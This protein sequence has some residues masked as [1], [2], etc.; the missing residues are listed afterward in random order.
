MKAWLSIDFEDI[1]HDFK[2]EFGIAQDGSL[3]EEALWRSYEAIEAFARAELGGA[4]LTFFTTGIVAEKCP[5]IVARIARDGHEVACHNLWH[6]PARSEPPESFESNLRRAVDALEAASGQRVLGFR[7]PRFSLR[8]GDAGHFR[9]LDRLFAYDSSL[10]VAAGDD[11]AALRRGLGLERLILLPV[12]RQKV[13]RGLPPLRSGGAY[14]KLFPPGVTVRNLRLAAEAGLAPM[15]YLHPYEFAA[16]RAFY[17]PLSEM[18]DL[19]WRRKV[20]LWARQTHCHVI[21]NRSVPE[22]LRRI[23]AEVEIAGPMRELVAARP[24]RPAR[25]EPSQ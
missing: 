23:A 22:K 15:L 6:D 2:R 1:A 13:V 17:F 9:V 24:Q 25:K 20:F 12:V 7:A 11:V 10:T 21:G 14:L 18:G 4:R 5:G 19:A 3:R 16:D 8:A